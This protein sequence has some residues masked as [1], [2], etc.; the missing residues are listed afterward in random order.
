VADLAHLLAELVENATA[1]SPP[2]TRVQVQGEQ[3][4]AGYVVEIED[5]GLG[6]GVET[7]SDANRRIDST[8]QTD[9]FDS[10]RLGLFV[11]SRL[12]RRHEIRVALR[13]SAYGGTTA[14]VLLP[15]ALLGGSETPALAR[16]AAR[17]QQSI[18]GARRQG[19]AER[20]S[21]RA[22]VL[23][24]AASGSAPGATASG[25]ASTPAA[26]AA[27]GSDT[28]TDA[29]TRTGSG[30]QTDSAPGREHEHNRE[31]EADPA[32]LRDSAGPETPDGLP[33]RVRQANL[34]P[35]LRNEDGPSPSAADEDADPTARSPEQAR[36]TMAA[37]QNGWS[38]G[39]AS[40]EPAEG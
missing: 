25:A 18:E 30:P 38:L 17:A 33:R 24:G 39:R 13:P 11:V 34:A 5:R 6:M 12:A 21:G 29:R 35:G 10:D 2:H 37:Y 7:L 31:A 28:G 40:S 16:P 26:A 36:A 27:S 23:V 8:R 1:F 32:T 19:A 9:L 3:V 14:V 22:A 4:A 20:P 15:K